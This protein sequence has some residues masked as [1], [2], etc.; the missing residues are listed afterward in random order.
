MYGPIL[1]APNSFFIGPADADSLK[2]YFTFNYYLKYDTGLWFTGMNYPHGELNIF[3]DNQ[4]I[5]SFLLNLIDDHLFPIAPYGVGIMNYLNFISIVLAAQI[6]YGILRFFKISPWVAIITGVLVVFL[7]PQLERAVPHITLSYMVLIPAAWL[8]TIKILDGNFSLKNTVLINLV[9]LVAT[10]VHIYYFLML[11]ILIWL[12]LFLDTLHSRQSLRRNLN[13]FGS[14]LIVAIGVILLIKYIDP[15]PDRPEQPWGV[16]YFRSYFVTIF[17]PQIP[18]LLNELQSVFNYRHRPFEG[19]SYV[20]LLGI[21]MLLYLGYCLLINFRKYRKFRIL[22]HKLL[23]ISI[24]SAFVVL[25]FAMGVFHDNLPN[26]IFDFL[27]P[28]RQIRSLG[29]FSWIFYYIFTVSYGVVIWH[30]YLKYQEKKKS[31]LAWSILILTL[32]VWAYD[33]YN[34]IKYVSAFSVHRNT[35]ITENNSEILE[36][37]NKMGYVPS[38]FQAIMVLPYVHVGS[39]KISK[40]QHGEIMNVAFEW[41]FKT[42]LPITNVLMS[43]TSLSQTLGNIQLLSSDKIRKKNLRKINDKPFLV[44]TKLKITENSEIRLLSKAL[45]IHTLGDTEVWELPIESFMDNVDNYKQNFQRNRDSFQQI[46]SGI[47]SDTIPDNLVYFSFDDVINLNSFSGS[48][49]Y[50]AKPDI[51]T[52]SFTL[53]NNSEN[54]DYELAFWMRLDHR[55]TTTSVPEFQIPGD[56]FQVIKLNIK[57]PSEIYG[58]WIRVS[59]VFRHLV[60]DKEYH[61]ILTDQKEVIDELIVRPLDQD[62][63]IDK[64][65]ELLLNNYILD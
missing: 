6:V 10:F 14:T 57:Q 13:V 18:P 55:V 31:K 3:T 49:A 4:P 53:P 15:I 35:I 42:G 16:S 61:L 41:S 20:G 30:T 48:G 43:R 52:I 27:K 64:G 45:K 44:I 25:L 29:R 24:I 22:N 37:F 19:I 12:M 58:H 9:I 21:P 1:L 28:L 65:H 60:S 26:F 32:V 51:D 7:S 62:I 17:L 38:D 56:H 36:I 23:D 33:T 54:R 34:N 8:L 50:T 5:F 47:Y 59:T 39:E 40:I 63:Y 11:I 2:N 46:Q